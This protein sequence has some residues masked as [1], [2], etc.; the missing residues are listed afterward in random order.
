MMSGKVDLNEA[1]R[2]EETARGVAYG[3]GR[4]AYTLPEILRRDGWLKS[5][6]QLAG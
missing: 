2:T 5:G 6:A 1:N 4:G 3:V